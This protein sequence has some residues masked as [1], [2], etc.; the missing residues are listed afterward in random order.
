MIQIL[1]IRYVNGMPG[2]FGDLNTYLI[3]TPRE[4]DIIET[5]M[6]LVDAIFC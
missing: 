2:E 3:M 6:G 1:Y 4:H 5:A